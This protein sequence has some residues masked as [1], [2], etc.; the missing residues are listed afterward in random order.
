MNRNLLSKV[1]SS[2]AE[3]TAPTS[4]APGIRYLMLNEAEKRKEKK[5]ATDVGHV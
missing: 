2:A 5:K 1:D 3:W 4:S